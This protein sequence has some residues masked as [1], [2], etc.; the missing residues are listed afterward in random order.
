MHFNFFRVSDVQVLRGP[1]P[2]S[3]QEF[4][5]ED[6]SSPTQRSTKERQLL[7]EPGLGEVFSGADFKHLGG[8]RSQ[9]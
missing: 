7:L 3:L 4:R 9:R 6:F 5:H 1:S 8:E 2:Q